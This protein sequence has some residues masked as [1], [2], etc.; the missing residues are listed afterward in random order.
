MGT[1][2]IL[3]NRRWWFGGS[4][5]SARILSEL[6]VL[7]DDT[8]ALS[9]CGGAELSSVSVL[10]GCGDCVDCEADCGGSSMRS[11]DDLPVTWC[12]D[13]VSS[14]SDIVESLQIVFPLRRCFYC[15]SRSRPRNDT[16]HHLGILLRRAGL[17]CG[18]RI[19][20]F[21]SETKSLSRWRDILENV[22]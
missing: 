9:S 8:E 17:E 6:L 18:E 19:Y 15:R 1:L 14:G 12:G 10:S 3:D 13:F 20:L 7:L 22:E 2:I 16:I 4:T 11:N 21:S 5:H